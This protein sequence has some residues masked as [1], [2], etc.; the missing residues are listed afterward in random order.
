MRYP[1]F[2][3]QGFCTSTGVV[4]AGY[5]VVIGTRL[6]RAG[7]HWTVKGANAIIALGCSKLSGRFE[8]FWERR[9]D[10]SKVAAYF[11]S[12]IRRAPM[13]KRHWA[14]PYRARPIHQSTLP[15][16][17]QHDSV[18]SET[19]TY[20]RWVGICVALLPMCGLIGIRFI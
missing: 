8:D 7:M 16:T 3:K 4:E 9:S 18:A 20:S 6:K 14:S 10:Q 2:H 15:M 11:T 17:R 5:K 1:K 12:Q 19:D 13:R